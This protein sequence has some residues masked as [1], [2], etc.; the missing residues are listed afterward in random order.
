VESLELDV[1]SSSSAAR[2]QAKCQTVY[3]FFYFCGQDQPSHG[4]KTA[5]KARLPSSKPAHATLRA[6]V[7]SS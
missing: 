3:L 2:E 7:E 6:Y 1:G 5:I 4:R